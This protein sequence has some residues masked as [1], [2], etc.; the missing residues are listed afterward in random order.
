MKAGYEP[1]PVKVGDRIKDYVV[2]FENVISSG[3]ED[4]AGTI[5][6]ISQKPYVLT[7]LD[8]GVK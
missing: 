2:Y 6:L 1:V 3:T 5:K 8:G 4:E 7:Y